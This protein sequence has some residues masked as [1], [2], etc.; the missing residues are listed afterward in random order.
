LS[1][2]IKKKL[3]IL[4]KAIRKRVVS[5]VA[6]LIKGAIVAP[7]VPTILIHPKLTEVIYAG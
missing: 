3:I 7:R 1:L 5:A 4:R 6:S 2:C